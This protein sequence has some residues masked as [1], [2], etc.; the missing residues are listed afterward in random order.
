MLSCGALERIKNPYIDSIVEPFVPKN[1]KEIIEL[2]IWLGRKPWKRA[3]AMEKSTHELK[4]EFMKREK[5][6]ALKLL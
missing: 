2:W 1:Q 5:L 3:E 4:A 6:T